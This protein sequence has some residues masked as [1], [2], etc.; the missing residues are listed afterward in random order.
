MLCWFSS[1]DE[2][3]ARDN[4]ANKSDI[5]PSKFQF[6]WMQEGIQRPN[7]SLVFSET[8]TTCLFSFCSDSLASLFAN[9]RCLFSL[10]CCL[11]VVVF[12]YQGR[13]EDCASKD[14]KTETNVVSIF[15]VS[16]KAF[17]SVFCRRIQHE[18]ERKCKK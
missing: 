12:L 8:R 16:E 10:V 7:D 2:D 6:R 1:R 15:L 11:C 17:R 5:A 3:G 14:G 18:H 13:F 9:V 4:P